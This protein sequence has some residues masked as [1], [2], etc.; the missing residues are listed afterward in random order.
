M[1]KSDYGRLWAD[2]KQRYIYGYKVDEYNLPK[3][4]ELENDVYIYV[5]TPQE[6][7]FERPV[8]RKLNLFHEHSCPFFADRRDEDTALAG[9]CYRVL[10]GTKKPEN[11]QDFVDFATGWIEQNFEPLPNDTDL[12][13]ETFRSKINMPEWRKLEYDEAWNDVKGRFEQM[14]LK[15]KDVDVMSFIKEESYP[16]PKHARMINARNDRFKVCIGPFFQAISDYVFTKPFFIKLIPVRQRA[17][18]VNMLLGKCAKIFESDFTS[19]E[20]SHNPEVM[21]GV[22]F[23]FYRHMTKLLPN[24][25]V[26]LYLLSFLIQENVIKLGHILMKLWGKRMSGEMNTSLGNSIMN[27]LLFEYA[28]FVL[29]IVILSVHEGDDGLIGIDSDVNIEDIEAIINSLGYMIKLIQHKYVGDASFCGLVFGEDGRVIRE[30]YDTL[31]NFDCV[32]EKYVGSNPKTLAYL[33]RCKAL[34]LLCECLNCPILDSFARYIIRCTNAIDTAADPDYAKKFVERFELKYNLKQDRS[35]FEK[36]FNQEIELEKQEILYTTRYAFER[37][38]NITVACQLYLEKMFDDAT[39][40][41]NF[42]DPVLEHLLPNK[43]KEHARRY[44]SNIPQREA[45]VT[46]NYR[47]MILELPGMVEKTNFT[48][49]KKTPNP[50]FN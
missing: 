4:M 16:S 5:G 17:A 29:K 6:R 23:L 24:Q 49:V 1:R 45:R 21:E 40:L 25:N 46:R 39:I 41:Q 35:Y 8:S 38:F 3:L 34:S 43:Y 2:D 28:A 9:C 33:S 30:P 37:K 19:Y 42:H 7:K 10:R 47:K 36:L 11:I 27:K 20:S 32:K 26:F 31:I 12:T 15:G 50:D 13:Y 44:V 18:Y 14:K 48:F 22:E